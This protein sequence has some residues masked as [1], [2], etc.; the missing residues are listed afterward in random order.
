MSARDL[1]SLSCDPAPFIRHP[2]SADALPRCNTRSR[3]WL[4]R[5]AVQ[6]GVGCRAGRDAERCTQSSRAAVR[7]PAVEERSIAKPP[8][9]ACSLP[10]AAQ[11]RAHCSHS[12]LT[13]Q[14][15]R[16]T[17]ASTRAANT[18]RHGP[19]VSANAGPHAPALAPAQRD[20]ALALPAR[21]ARRATRARRRS[22]AHADALGLLCT[23]GEGKDRTREV[24][25]GERCSCALRASSGRRGHLVGAR[26]GCRLAAPAGSS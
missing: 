20:A 4:A 6:H 18:R 14:L 15:A 25:Q 10:R 12:S 7:G 11:S 9:C 24:W 8:G 3:R 19:A 22:R 13:D 17:H 1:S 5:R 16:H 23:K 26:G 21:C 2:S